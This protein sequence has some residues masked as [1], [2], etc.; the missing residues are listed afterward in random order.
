MGA[1]SPNQNTSRIQEKDIIDLKKFTVACAGP[2]FTRTISSI[3]AAAMVVQNF[4]NL[5]EVARGTGRLAAAA[6]YDAMLPVLRTQYHDSFYDP[7]S[8][9]YGDGT[10]TAFGTALWLGV[11]PSNLLPAVVGNFVKQLASTNFSM[12]S[13]GFIGV[14][15]IFEALAMHN[16][17][18]VALAMLNVTQYPSFGY[19]ITNPLEPATSLWESFDAPTMHQWVDESSRDHHYSA[20]I[21]TF[22]RKFLA[23]L[24]QPRGKAA[25]EV[26]RCRPEAAFWPQHLPV[27]SAW[28]ST[29]RG[30]VGCAWHATPTAGLPQPLPP[31][32]SV[33]PAVRCAVTPQ[34]TGALRGPAPMVFRCPSNSSITSIVYAKWGED[35]GLPWLCFGAQ[36]PPKGPNAAACNAD[37]RKK[38]APLCIG[39]ATCDLGPHANEAFLGDPCRGSLQKQ[40]PAENR[41]LPS[42]HRAAAR[43]TGPAPN[44]LIVRVSCSPVQ[45]VGSGTPRVQPPLRNDVARNSRQGA[46]KASSRPAPAAATDVWATVDVTVPSGSQGEVHV[47]VVS[48]TAGTVT[49][50]ECGVVWHNGSFMQLGTC[51]GVT[52]GGSDGRFVWFHVDAGNYSFSASTQ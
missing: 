19:Q 44:Q 9:I 32:A 39:K 38:I 46:S 25:W 16:R 26:V 30:T 1:G 45:A 27:A 47:P 3:T 12:S 17:T 52:R 49:E 51:T 48:M 28:L 37:V 41:P 4:D 31:G 18:D 33:L 20:S 6:R 43:S 11:T 22:L 14:R 15:Y 23:G 36:P 10:P 5:A 34:F 29:R 40:A 21:N 2:P 8:K 24:T 42:V 7:V 50:I 35:N 13:V